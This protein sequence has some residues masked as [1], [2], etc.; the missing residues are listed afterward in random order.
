MHL[1]TERM[2]S[3]TKLQKELTRKLRELSQNSE[4]LFI[5]K[6]NLLAA[7]ILHPAEYEVLRNAESILEQFEI[8]EMVEARLKNY[9]PSKKIPWTRVK[10][11]RGI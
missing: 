4:P 9:D 7:V 2:I 8:A 10:A 5:M 11:D 3:I 1:E 6:N